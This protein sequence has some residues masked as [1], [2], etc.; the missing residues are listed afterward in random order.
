MR[1]RDLCMQTKA[2]D[3]AR[4]DVKQLTRDRRGLDEGLCA[5]VL[6]DCPL[7]RARRSSTARAATSVEPQNTHTCTL[8]VIIPP[9]CRK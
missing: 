1:Q 2:N 6:M 5:L 9:V 4:S 3:D 7:D 8:T